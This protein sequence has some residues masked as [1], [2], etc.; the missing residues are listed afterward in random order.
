MDKIAR[1][2]SPRTFDVSLPA[3]T[4]T[5]SE[6]Q[7]RPFNVDV[8]TIPSGAL[9]VLTTIV[10][11]DLDR[12]SKRARRDGHSDSVAAS[13]LVLQQLVSDLEWEA[14]ERDR[15]RWLESRQ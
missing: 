12:L 8:A 15:A 6:S 1:E 2:T 4:E 13:K 11:D 3:T 14:K 7:S 10:L 5:R 9:G